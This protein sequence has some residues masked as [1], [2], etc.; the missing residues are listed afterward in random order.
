MIHDLFFKQTPGL[1]SM[2]Q[3]GCPKMYIEYMERRL[4][5][6]NVGA[7]AAARLAAG[8]CQVVMP[9]DVNWKPAE[10]GVAVASAAQSFCFP[11]CVVITQPVRDKAKLIALAAH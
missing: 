9:I 11:K 4:V 6:A 10:N 2:F 5:H 3:K 8:A 1:L 7:Q